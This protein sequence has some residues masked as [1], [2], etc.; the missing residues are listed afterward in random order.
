MWFWSFPSN[1]N[2]RKLNSFIRKQ[3]YLLSFI[4]GFAYGIP[5]KFRVKGPTYPRILPIGVSTFKNLNKFFLKKK[6]EG[7]NY[8]HSQEVKKNSR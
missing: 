3:F 6:R 2:F 7:I 1:I 4:G 5:K 8:L